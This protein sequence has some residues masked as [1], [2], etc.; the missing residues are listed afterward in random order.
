MAQ[1]FFVEIGTEELPPKSLKLLATSFQQNIIE[2]L[3][4]LE[5][6][7][8]DSQW[9]AA[10]RRLAVRINQLAAQQADKVVE[11][12]G[13]AL[14]GAFDAAGQPTKAA[15]AWAAANGITVEQA[16]RLET[17]KGA[18]LIHKAK[19]TGQATV[20]LLEQVIATALAKLPIAR[21]MRWGSSDAEFIRPVHTVT[22][23]YGNDVVPA[24]V[25]GIRADR[26]SLGH[27]FH[28]PS[29]VAIENAD[30]YLKVLEKSYVVADY[31][32][33]KA[34]IDEQVHFVAKSLNGIAQM[35]DALL[36]EV[37]SLVEWKR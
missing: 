14:A 30:A 5:L 32:R 10:P 36:E 27:R 29:K 33:R 35:D 7:F 34:Y 16:E 2:E 23:L 13:P 15:S 25:L 11:K 9:Y 31:E 37:T 3:N 22:M 19:V 24:T 4:R 1:D 18:W 26:L 21:P 28:A 12:R 8:S 17:D 20:A 6:T